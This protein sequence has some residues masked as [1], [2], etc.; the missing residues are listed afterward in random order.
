MTD[1][2]FV[3]AWPDGS[4]RDGLAALPRSVE[5]GVRWVPPENW[6][7]T[8][9]FLG[10]ADVDEVATRLAGADLPAVR[11]ELG[12][13]IEWLG[14][15]LVVP[16]SGVDDLAAAVALATADVGELPRH[17]FRG[18]LTVARTRRHA[19]SAMAGLPCTGGFDVADIALVR[20]EL[21]PD[22]ASYT[23][24]ATFPTGG[25]SNVSPRG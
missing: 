25:P 15:Q 3:A 10:T 11:A 9:R 2:L 6:H 4:T 1:R 14:T 16:V 7:V 19:T 18:H 13:A 12:P 24:I 22:G 8:L 21:L 5:D 20:S 17:R 23:T